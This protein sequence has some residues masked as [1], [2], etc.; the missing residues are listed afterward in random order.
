MSRVR[1]GFAHVANNKYDGWKMYAVGGNANPTIF[2][3]GN[4]YVA[5]KNAAFKEASS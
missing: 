4:Y 3:E 2:S 1:F 5:P